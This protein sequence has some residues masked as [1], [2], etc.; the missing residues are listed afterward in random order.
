M[1]HVSL[2]SSENHGKI[3]H[4][5]EMAVGSVPIATLDQGLEDDFQ[6]LPGKCL[7]LT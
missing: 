1:F 6:Y 5:P 3:K 2:R 4:K 7:F